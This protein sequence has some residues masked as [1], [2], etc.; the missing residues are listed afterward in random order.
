MSLPNYPTLEAWIAQAAIPFSLDVPDSL[1]AAADALVGALDPAVELLG[2]GEALHGGEEILLL[3]SRLFARLAEAHGFSAIAFESSFP[4]GRL[5]NEYVA[6]RGPASYEAAQEAG[7]SHGF[8]RLAAIRELIEWMR[9][10]N[11]DP[12]HGLKLRFYGFDGPLEMM[13]AESPRQL[14]GQALDF[15]GS[16]DPAAGERF[17]ARVEPLLGD[18]SAWQNPAAMFDSALSVGG[19]P[20]AAA[21]RVATEDL[22]AELQARRPELVAATGPESLADALHDAA[23]A[24]Q[25]LNYHAAVARPA[26]NRTAWLLGLR[27]ALMANN[28]AYVVERERGRGKVLVFA[29]NSHLQRSPARWQ[30]GPDLLTWWPAGAHMHALLGP[31]Y[32]LVGTAVGWSEPNGIGRP[33]PGTLEALLTAAP[34]PLRLIPT[35]RGQGLP[36]DAIAALPTRV[37]GVLN[38]SYTTPLGP[39]SFADFDW[40]A[41]LDS[42]AYARGGP[43][44]PR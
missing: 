29:H 9:A 39:H 10:R 38:T 19:S 11:A 16:V 4:R 34:G 40:L 12:A 5:M 6:G 42:V 43:P 41:V 27:D 37:G 23:Q 22:I 1:D 17:R 21:L 31:R 44:L 28:L 20:A 26:P 35:F 25:L 30:L 14:L 13:G 3:L 18:E 33:E 7:W 8:G 2:F 32:A 24:R 36:A 15:L